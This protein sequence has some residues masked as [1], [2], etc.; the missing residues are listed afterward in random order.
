MLDGRSRV[1]LEQNRGKAVLLGFW[2]VYCGACDEAQPFLS[3]LYAGTDKARFALVAVN[4]GDDPEDV[5]AYV[6]EKKIKYPLALDSEHKAVS[7]FR[8]RGTPAFILIDKKGVERARWLGYV[9]E[10][11]SDI[12]NAIKKIMAEPA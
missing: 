1:T 11:E 12:R 2:S 8:V 7:A 9:P 6:A 10:L 5:R 4:T 3:S